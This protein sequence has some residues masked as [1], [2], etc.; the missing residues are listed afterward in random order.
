MKRLFFHTLIGV[1]L[2]VLYLPSVSFTQDYSFQ[3]SDAR[4]MQV[5]PK[6]D[7]GALILG[8]FAD[9][10][11]VGGK[12]IK[13]PRGSD[14]KNQLTYYLQNTD[15]KENTLWVKV[16][17]AKVML[18]GGFEF[19][20]A[21][22]LAGD[23]EESGLFDDSPRMVNYDKNGFIAKL[24]DQGKWQ[25][26]QGIGGMAR[27]I[28]SD[29]AGN[30]L[31]VVEVEGDQDIMGGK[32]IAP[33][34][35]KN[36]I[37]VKISP[38]GK[39]LW[40]AQISGGKDLP[41]VQPPLTIVNA[42]AADPQGNVY[43]A[44]HFDGKALIGTDTSQE[45]T[46]ITYGPGE[47]LYDSETFVAKF[48][49][50]GQL[51]SVFRNI[52]KLDSLFLI[53]LAV[54]ASGNAYLTGY[55]QGKYIWEHKGQKP[56]SEP[57][58]M[59][60]ATEGTE[61]AFLLKVRDM[62]EVEWIIQ[63]EGEGYDRGDSIILGKD[64]IE[65]LISFA[66]T[67]KVQGKTFTDK[68]GDNYTSDMLLLTVDLAGN[69]KSAVQVQGMG[70][71]RGK[72]WGSGDARYLYGLTFYKLNQGS[73]DFLV[74][75]TGNM[76]GDKISRDIVSH[77]Q[78]LKNDLSTFKPG[79][80]VKALIEGVW[81][82]GTVNKTSDKYY[83]L[84]MDNS[85]P[86]YWKWVLPVYLRAPGDAPESKADT[87]TPRD[88]TSKD[89]APKDNSSFSAQDQVKILWQGQWYNGKILKVKDGKYYI[90]YD[91]YSEEWNEWVGPD[92]L[93]KR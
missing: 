89:T 5:V 36:N 74:R 86:E 46:K 11:V 72:L 10:M 38:E 20:N 43:V 33:G 68:T 88:S 75:Y 48:S 62:K 53:D 15:S 39:V 31:A 73:Y 54:D 16:F 57:L 81:Y 13:A 35:P 6:S 24:S 44:G 76:P 14:G 22:Y 66:R 28:N 59:Y 52:E 37:L 60:G 18:R 34:Y 51:I 8:W 2:S 42:V 63:P 9:P 77:A 12:S 65:F 17:P 7:G 70:G 64:K 27:D 67:I 71:E 19:K 49:P 82:T 4:Y 45:A 92:R 25:W 87:T 91:G 61:D 30:I 80:K 41:R 26:V 69:I 84:Q 1:F 83:L 29:N 21:F 23:M 90:K 93:K 32:K 47:M 3:D 78:F 40:T 55:V 50:E 79:E 58:Q 85:Q 56:P